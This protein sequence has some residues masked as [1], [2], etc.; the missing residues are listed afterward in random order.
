MMQLTYQPAF[1]PYHTAYRL[2][3]LREFVLQKRSLHEDQIKILDF[4]LLFPF[5]IEGLRLSPTHRKYRKLSSH[6]SGMKPYGELPDDRILFGRMGPLQIAAL[7]TLAVKGLINGEFYETGTIA[8]TAEEL[9]DALRAR[10]AAA[11]AAQSDLMEFLDVLAS[12]YDL[13]GKDGLKDRSQLMEYRYD[14]I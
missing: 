2:L 11:N 9:H 6:Y 14:A 7:D 5:R 1:D 8:K 13:L 12:E 4:Y 10:L 3:R